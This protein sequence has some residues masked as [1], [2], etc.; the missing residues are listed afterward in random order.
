MHSTHKS[1]GRILELAERIERDIH[2]RHLKAGD[3]YYNTVETAKMLHVDTATVNQALQLLVK[4]NVVVRRQRSGTFISS[5]PTAEDRPVL[6]RVH[7][8]VGDSYPQTEGWL[9]PQVVMN[10]QSELPGV[11]IQWHSVP[12]TAEEEYLK[13]TIREGL[14]S[15]LLE[16]YVLTRAS[17]TMQRMMAS[18]GLPVALFGRPYASL[19]QLPY[20][21]RDQAQIGCLTAEYLIGRGHRR[22]AMFMRQRVLRGDHLM[23]DGAR[24]VAGRAGLGADRFSIHCLPQDKEE[25]GYVVGEL[26]ADKNDPPGIIVRSPTMA[27][28]VLDRIRSSGR[29]L[30]REVSLVVSDYFGSEAPPYAYIEPEGGTDSQVVRLGRLIWRLA[31]GKTIRVEDQRVPVQLT[32]PKGIPNR[33]K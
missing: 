15:P 6:E 3:R 4:R 32:V 20:I 5:G 13:Q 1:A 27:Q 24:I 10:L 2:E 21:E 14:K 18:S 17:L 19:P 26:L 23:M 7:L 31:C 25:I 28:V 29:K 9:T 33:T 8:L 11:R 30:H 22:I 16:G 12:A